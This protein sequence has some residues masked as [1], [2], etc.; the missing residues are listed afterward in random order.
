MAEE[1]GKEKRKIGGEKCKGGRGVKEKR[2]EAGGKKEKRRKNT[3]EMQGKTER[4]KCNDRKRKLK[5]D[6]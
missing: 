1:R 5:M 2:D 4:R 3:G 6:D